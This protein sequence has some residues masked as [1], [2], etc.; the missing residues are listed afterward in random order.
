MK[1]H[2]SSEDGAQKKAE[3]AKM[4]L[5]IYGLPQNLSQ[6]KTFR[7]GLFLTN[8]LQ[9]NNIVKQNSMAKDNCPSFCH[10]RKVKIINGRRHI[11]CLEKLYQ[12]CSP[13]YKI[14]KNV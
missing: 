8:I 10:S 11:A 3:S 2:F 12:D 9:M 1:L 4:R 5:S 13:K 6:L 14:N 7:N